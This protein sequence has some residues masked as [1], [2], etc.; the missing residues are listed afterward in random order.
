MTAYYNEIDPFAAHLLRALIADDVITLGEVDTRSIA[1]VVPSDLVGFTQCHFFA[2]GGCWSVA[3]RLAGWPDERQLWTGSCPCQPFSTAGRRSGT[4]DDRH[5][6]P[7]FFRLIRACRPACV[8]GEQVAGAAG[9]GWFDGVRFDLASAAYACR[10]V[11]IP[12]CAID[13]PH[14]RQ[15]LYWVAVAD[16]ES[17]GRLDRDGES[18][19]SAALEPQRHR[20]GGVAASIVSP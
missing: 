6:W 5:L 13:A 8:V 7:H 11:D 17:R 14:I 2:G 9:Y 16:R 1:D 20:S 15:R 18:G 4:A 19:W 10:A 3:A 12:A